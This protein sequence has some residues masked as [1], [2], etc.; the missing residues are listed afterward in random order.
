MPKPRTLARPRLAPLLLA[1]VVLAAARVPAARTLLPVLG[2]FTGAL[3][4]VLLA[5]GLALALRRLFGP[6]PCVPSP[7]PWLLFSVSLLLAAPV[8][9]GYV[10]SVEPSGDEIDYLLMTQSVWREGDLDL[11][12]NFERGDYLEYLGG[13]DRMPGGFRIRGRYYPTHSGGLAVVLAPAY[14]LG[15]RVGCA[16]LL[17]LVAAG[18]GLLVRDIAE[19]ATGDPRA[20]LVAWAAAVGPPVLFY[21]AFLYSEVVVAFCIALALRLVLWSRGPAAAALAAL[22]LAALPWLHLRMSLAA[23][24]IGSF[25]LVRLRG[26]ERGAFFA[27]GAL[28]AAAYIGSQYASFG[29]LSPLVRYGGALPPGMERPTPFRTLFGLFLDGAYGLLPYAPVFLLAL[30]GLPLLVSRRLRPAAGPEPTGATPWRT[31]AWSVLAAAL[32][33]LVPVLTW[34]NW[35]GFSPPARFTIPLLPVLAIALAGRL[36][37]HPGR[38]LARWRWPLAA[39]GV[40]L[41]LFLFAHPRAMLM[42]NGR[43]GTAHG[44]D[45]LAGA[46]SF[47]RY[48][49][50]LSSRLGS[51]APP[52]E[53]P[54]AEARVAAVWVIALL[55]LLA[56]DRLAWTKHRVDRWF[57]GLAL[58]LVLLL[59]VSIGVDRWARGGQGSASR[60]P[61]AGVLQGDGGGHGAEA[62][63]SGGASGSR[64]EEVG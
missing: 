44:F 15:G 23:V 24:A 32:G 37:A 51:T 2:L 39:L 3:G 45:A 30:A 13:L 55:A 60:G 16:V 43:G 47:S 14:A 46:V 1:A 25:A 7:G 56:L 48:L 42:V 27:V 22:A 11:R 5:G 17:V 6:G 61:A 64:T 36:A 63:G 4:W 21:T 12:D 31:V 40:G 53:P 9:I 38:G 59:G 10:R 20:A 54:A 33:I 62:M 52:W 18:L 26:R 49:P 28:M 29:T 58:P 19:R 50:F 35:W 8:A 34:R 41:A 57:S